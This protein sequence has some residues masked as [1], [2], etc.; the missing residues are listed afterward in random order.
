MLYLAIPAH[1]EA[2][3]IGVLLWRLRT[4]LAEFPREYEA[5]VYDDA[6]TDSTLDIIESYTSVMPLT[7][8]RGERR[9]GYAGAVDALAR[10]VSRQTR[11]PRRDAM[12]LMQGDFTDPPA[13][14][15]EFVK[16]FEG[17][18]DIVVGERASKSL[19]SAPVS[20][21]RLLRATPWLLRFFVGVEGVRDLTS[22]YRLVRI[23]VLRDLLRAVGDAPLSVGDSTTANAE[24]LLRLVPHARR[25]EAVEIEP[26]WDVRLRET[27]VVAMSDSLALFRWGWRAR[28]RRAV[29]STLPE[30]FND[31]PRTARG[32]RNDRDGRDARVDSRIDITDTSASSLDSSR[33]PGRDRTSRNNKNTRPIRGGERIVDRTAE[34]ANDQAIAR[35][36]ARDGVRNSVSDSVREQSRDVARDSALEVYPSNADAGKVAPNAERPA[37]RKRS[38]GR[39]GDRS[40]NSSALASDNESDVAKTELRIVRDENPDHEDASVSDVATASTTREDGVLSPALDDAVID[41][42][43]SLDDPRRLRPARKKRRRGG[44]RLSAGDNVAREVDDGIDQSSEDSAES[45]TGDQE[46]SGTDSIDADDSNDT[47]ASATEGRARRRGRRGR[48]GGS[49][50]G[51]QRSEGGTEGEGGETSYSPPP[52]A[53]SPPS[54]G[55]N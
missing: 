54:G 25:V 22:S 44:G 11:Y 47:N 50:R 37:H 28:G 27:R 35:S 18:A 19:R 45:D 24:L 41:A 38:R 8:L 34:R 12:L 9:V 49:R 43:S 21:R 4:V 10:H 30:S 29:P 2:A 39:R 40:E 36:T 26:T 48:R 51:R 15:P 13:L 3:T 1:N 53:Q 42:E 52:E 46:L 33:Q 55:D 7:V 14:V 6:S 16:R 31:A 17:G 32:A 23:S 20:V 5:V